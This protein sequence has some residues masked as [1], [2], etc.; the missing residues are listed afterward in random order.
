MKNWIYLIIAVIVVLFIILI[1][2]KRNERIKNKLK[3]IQEERQNLL[4]QTQQKENLRNRLNKKVNLNSR[5]S[6]TLIISTFITASI[7]A[8][9]WSLGKIDLTSLFLGVLFIE[10]IIAIISQLILH[11]PHEVKY[12]LAR[13]EPYFR[14]EIFASHPNLDGEIENGHKRIEILDFQIHRLQRLI[15]N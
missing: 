5:L 6:S 1:R 2:L 11:K 3:E 7:G 15:T 8:G 12:Y 14:S 13:I 4:L 9:F 10:A